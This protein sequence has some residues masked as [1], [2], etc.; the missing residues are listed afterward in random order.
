MTKQWTYSGR[1]IFTPEGKL[2]A[3]MDDAYRMVA[4]LNKDLNAGVRQTW[5]PGVESFKEAAVAQG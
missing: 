2:H 5:M 4:K 1:Y 3:T